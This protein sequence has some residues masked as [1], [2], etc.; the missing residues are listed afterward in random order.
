MKREK[1]FHKRFCSFRVPE[2]STTT[3]VIIDGATYHRLA[4][5]ART[6]PKEIRQQ[7]VEESKQHREW[8]E[9]CSTTFAEAK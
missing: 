2:D 1:R 9:V 6:N 5:A 3:S 7:E 8:I 4:H